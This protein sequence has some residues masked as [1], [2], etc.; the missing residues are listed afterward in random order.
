[1]RT[2][3]ATV[4]HI[5]H[6]GHLAARTALAEGWVWK[7][8][9]PKPTWKCESI[10][11]KHRH[12]HRDPKQHYWW[13]KGSKTSPFC[14]SCDLFF[15]NLG[16][17]ATLL[18]M[19]PLNHPQNHPT[20]TPQNARGRQRFGSVN[21]ESRPLA[22]KSWFPLWKLVGFRDDFGWGDTWLFNGRT[23]W[24]RWSFIPWFI[25]WK[26]TWFYTSQVVPGFF[27]QQ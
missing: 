20:K 21:S 19:A 26:I 10:F 22:S 5:N 14:C 11:S 2:T 25:P 6:D 18:N 3:Q 27:H 24:G 4:K 15:Q 9:N 13:R 16:C 12:T 8:M 17:S 1:M 7:A 23:S